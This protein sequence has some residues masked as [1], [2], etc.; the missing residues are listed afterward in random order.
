MKKLFQFSKLTVL[1]LAGTVANGHAQQKT[2]K[3]N[4]IIVYM[5]DMGYGDVAAYGGIDYMTPNIDKLAVQGMRFTNFYSAQPVC[6]A[7]RA[8][9]L[10]GCYPNRIGIH[11]ALVPRSK[12]GLSDQEETIASTLKKSGY[13]TGIIGKWH[14]GDSEKFL[15]LQHGFDYFF[16]LPYSN[17]MWPVD[18]DWTMVTDT[19]KWRGRIPPLAL[20]DGNKTLRHIT[21]QEEQSMLTTWYTQKATRFIKEHKGQPFFLYLAHNMVHVPL[22]VSDKFR[23]KS[24]QGLFGDVMMEIDWSMGELMKALK[25][26][27]QENNTLLI[28]TA[29]NGP[30]LLFGNHGGS[31]GGLRE[32]K[33]TTW[34][35][36]VKE[37]AIMRWPGVIPAGTIC[38]KLAANIDLLPTAAAIAGAP[39]PARKIDGV[40]IL[41]LLKGDQHANPRD[42]MYYYYQKNSLEAVRQGEW[43]LVFP[44]RYGSFVDGVPGVDG[45]PGKSRPD[46]TGLALYDLRRDPGERYDVK[47]KHPNIVQQL[48]QL[49]EQARE[50]L[51]DDLTNRPG[52]NR[53]SPGTL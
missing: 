38:N 35:G 25:E 24:K 26:T 5:D 23:G 45:W 2:A 40:N 17:D 28:F 16:G 44:H 52:R 31:A 34:D 10:T 47:D 12:I 29:D 11:G 51:G 49:A 37:P 42:H 14:L 43:K 22:A 13:F 36:G 4:I 20:I 48:Q 19:T 9:L 3:P 53:R 18:Y 30:W 6:S 39:L 1:A 21:T 46:S 41:P 7:S 27:G 33:S 32:G 15:P 50:D 8:A